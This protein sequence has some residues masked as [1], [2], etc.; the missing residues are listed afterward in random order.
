MFG[1]EKPMFPYR[2]LP[3]YGC[4]VAKSKKGDSNVAELLYLII[5]SLFLSEFAPSQSNLAT[6]HRAYFQDLFVRP[7]DEFPALFVSRLFCP[8]RQGRLSTL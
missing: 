4:V 3:L 7:G 5:T 1:N 8:G 6:R 2:L